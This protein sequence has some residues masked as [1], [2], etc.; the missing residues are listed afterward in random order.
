MISRKAFFLFFT[1]LLL[2]SQCT[3][4]KNENADARMSPAKILSE[5]SRLL[6]NT[7]G[8]FHF[9]NAGMPDD[10]HVVKPKPEKKPDANAEPDANALEKTLEAIT[11]YRYILL[12]L[13]LAVTV[14]GSIGLLIALLAP[15][16]RIYFFSDSAMRTY[17][18]LL[19]FLFFF[20][21][22][23]LMHIIGDSEIIFVFAFLAGIGAYYL[24]DKLIQRQKNNLP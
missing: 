3:L 17:Y 1:V 13:L 6:D 23:R 20:V 24:A 14:F 10:N 21:L 11:D 4:L 12:Y 9:V 22:L 7:A 2:C 19:V 8:G 5:V 16:T 18:I 15:E